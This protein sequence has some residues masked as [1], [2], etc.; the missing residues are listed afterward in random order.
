M[1]LLCSSHLSVTT[2]IE[3][4]GERQS[5]P[6]L[7][8]ALSPH[9]FLSDSGGHHHCCLIPDLFVKQIEFLSRAR[10]CPASYCVVWGHFPRRGGCIKLILVRPTPPGPQQDFPGRDQPQRPNTTKPRFLL[11]SRTAGSN[12]RG[13]TR[14]PTCVPRACIKWVV[15]HSPSMQDCPLSMSTA[16]PRSC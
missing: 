16:S 4:R 1:R 7:Q 11:L 3:S 6:L 12:L 15:H 5:E 13:L 8:H 14:S 2:L 9:V 10:D